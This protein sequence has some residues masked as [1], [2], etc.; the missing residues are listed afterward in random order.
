MKSLS[1]DFF[2]GGFEIKK[3]AASKGRVQRVNLR[4]VVGINSLNEGRFSSDYE[5]E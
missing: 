4:E 2:L 3:H 1:P 5:K